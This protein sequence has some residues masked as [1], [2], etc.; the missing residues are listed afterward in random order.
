MDALVFH[1]AACLSIV[2]A[3]LV[4]T[5][6]NPVFSA[7]SLVGFFVLMSIE[8]LILRAPFLA[9]LQVLVYVGA[10]MVLFIFVIMLLNLTEEDLREA[11]SPV[12]RATAAALSL[13]L[14]GL[15]CAAIS[16]SP[17]V[18][19]PPEAD[20]TNPAV[21]EAVASAGDIDQVGHS[22]FGTHIL[23]FEFTSILILVAI[24]GA[25]YLSKK[26]RPPA[27]SSVGETPAP[28]GGHLAARGDRLASGAEHPAS[29][30]E[31]PASG[32]EDLAA[33]GREGP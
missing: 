17:T 9:V 19:S 16:A 12:R 2:A 27:E 20:L 13:V 14:F 1:A 31:H 29:S 7:L 15:L 8:F 28:G 32:A 25:I 10:I 24:V 3:L 5:R 11:A 26:R 18:R 30:A 23:A 22:L 4:V 21:P 33:G 6:R